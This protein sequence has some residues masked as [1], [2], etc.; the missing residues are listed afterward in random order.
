[1]RILLDECAN[2]RL[3]RELVGH[4]VQ[5]VSQMGWGGIK[6]GALLSLAKKEFEIFL[7]IDRNLPFQQ[8]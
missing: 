2:R 8:R 3:A 1:M 5:T 7:T 6:N 4:D